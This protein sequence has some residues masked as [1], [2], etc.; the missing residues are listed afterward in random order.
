MPQITC[1][2]RT[3]TENRK[4]ESEYKKHISF[5]TTMIVEEIDQEFIMRLTIHRLFQS[6]V[7][8]E[9]IPSDRID[10]SIVMG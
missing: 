10:D 4:L 5:S 2:D 1:R 7:E 6:I 3:K 9:T 8:L